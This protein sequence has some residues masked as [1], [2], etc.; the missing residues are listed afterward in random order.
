MAGNLRSYSRATLD[1]WYDRRGLTYMGALANAGSG[2]VLVLGSGGERGGWSICRWLW[3]RYVPRCLR[4]WRS[5]SDLV[6]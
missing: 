6:N 4:C 5:P 2:M 3:A 1:G